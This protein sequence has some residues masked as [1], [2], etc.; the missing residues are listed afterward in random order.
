MSVGIVKRS[1]TDVE[2]GRK[3]AQ[4]IADRAWAYFAPPPE[5]TYSEWAEANVVLP[6]Y[7]AEPGKYRISRVPYMQEPMDCLCDP[8]IKQCVW[9]FAARTTKSQGLLNILGYHID[10]NPAPI[11]MI[12]P[13]VE[14]A[15]DFSKERVTPMLE[16]T[17]CLSGKVS[18]PRS[19]DSTNTILH[20]K[21][22]GGYLV[23]VG[24]NAPRGLRSWDAAV[25]LCDEVDGF[26]A[27]AGAEGDPIALATIRATTYFNPKIVISSTPTVRGES[28]IEE[29]Y[30]DSTQ[31]QWQVS[32]PD[33]DKFQPYNWE[34]V[35][36]PRL[37][38]PPEGKAE[39]EDWEKRP[40]EPL[41]S[42]KFCGKAFGEWA[43]KSRPAKWV[44]QR[45]HPNCRGFHISAMASPFMS[46]PALV[47]EY[48]TAVKA[49]PEQHQVFV[50][51][52][53]AELWNRQG[54]NV[55]EGLLEKR[56][57]DYNCDVPQQVCYLTCGIDVQKDRV[58]LE[59]VGWGQGYESW[60][61]EYKVIP[62]DIRYDDTKT[63][64]NDWLA[65]TYTREDGVVLPISIAAID[66]GYNQDDVLAF[67]RFRANQGV[68]AIKGMGGYGLPIVGRV[69]RHGRHKDFVYPVGVDSA[70][71]LL[72]SNLAVDEPGAGYCHY[73]TEA[74][75]NDGSLRGYDDVYFRGLLSETRKKR[76]VGGKIIA[77]WVKPTDIANEPLDT[78]VYAIAAVQ[79]LPPDF[80]KL[81]TAAA[82]SVEKKTSPLRRKR[83]WKIRSV[84]C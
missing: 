81:K 32:C 11:L 13:T 44:A 28:R 34:A 49:G 52:R 10:Q 25:I 62:G 35:I 74:T 51:T 72:F 77:T 78:R 69:G 24:A 37:P 2:A 5:L 1:K 75:F 80:E 70:K 60:G 18:D 68:V 57:H 82:V 12:R 19:R 16:D 29:A 26:P 6:D 17:P 7:S 27:S 71:D 79:I 55:N 54:E 58:E 4:K 23:M 15:Q 38:K 47:A 3:K 64:L 65:K 48:L 63:K 50:N 84:Q 22:D 14:D 30:L 41:M 31:E 8:N 45:E 56:V 76:R 20:K 59:V 67:T 73:P 40:T 46:W 21:F 53:L 66:S 36:F 83:N 33:C 39:R 42:C 9:M 61:I 43:W